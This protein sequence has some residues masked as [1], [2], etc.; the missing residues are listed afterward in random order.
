MSNAVRQGFTYAL[1]GLVGGRLSAFAVLIGLAVAG[2]DAMLT[3]SGHALTAIRW[4]GVC[5]LVWIGLVSLRRAW[6]EPADTT[7]AT[8]AAAG[9]LRTTIANEFV[10]AISNPKALL[11]FAALL[12]QFSNASGNDLRA[13]L[14]MLGA[15]YLAIELLVGL[16]YTW[17][18]S[19]IRAAGISSRSQRIVDLGSGLCVVALAGWLA[20]DD[21][22]EL[23][24]T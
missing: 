23:A 6:K 24:G 14:A 19:R 10:V 9:C 15:A 20:A 13:H 1:V 11:L 12:P 16:T 21:V 3:V 5:Y 2:L 7:T 4:V 18:G 8:P 22:N 17:I